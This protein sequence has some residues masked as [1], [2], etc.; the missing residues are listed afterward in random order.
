MKLCKFSVEDS[1]GPESLNA[2]LKELWGAE[3][4]FETSNIFNFDDIKTKTEV[5]LL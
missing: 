1:E 3:A 2:P 5:Y 4:P